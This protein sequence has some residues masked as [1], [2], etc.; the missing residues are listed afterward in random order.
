MSA[1]QRDVA[2]ITAMLNLLE[3]QELKARIEAAL[4]HE[5][6][7][8]SRILTADQTGRIFNKS[9]RTIHTLANQGLLRRV[10]LPGRKIGCGF[11]ES[12]VR[13]LLARSVE[14]VAP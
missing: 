3:S 4:K 7:E 6:A 10:K 8:T 12:D 2:T 5:E 1:P 14:G 9:A 13:S 11:L